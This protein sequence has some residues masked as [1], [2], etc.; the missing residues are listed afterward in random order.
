MTTEELQQIFK[1]VNAEVAASVTPSKI[2]TLMGVSDNNLSQNELVA[3]TVL[4][5][6]KLN[7]EFLFKVL[8]KALCND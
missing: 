1:S 2:K 5:G 3:R 8:A 6:I 4:A 7:Q